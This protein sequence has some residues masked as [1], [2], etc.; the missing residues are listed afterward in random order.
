MTCDE[1]KT[2]LQTRAASDCTRG[3]RAAVY[4]HL[5]KCPDCLR[6]MRAERL[7]MTRSERRES[8]RIGGEMHDRDI[9]DPE[10]V[11]TVYGG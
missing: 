6:F 1:V 5:M 9:Q 3:E 2:V 4:G 7:A 8:D 11:R 10:F